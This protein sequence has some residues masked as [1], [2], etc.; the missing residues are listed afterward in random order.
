[1]DR[2]LE[3]I[4]GEKGAGNGNRWPMLI[5]LLALAIVTAL[6][7]RWMSAG[8]ELRPNVAERYGV[9]ARLSE[10][11]DVDRDWLGTANPAWAGALIPSEARE[12]CREIIV[13]LPLQPGD[14]LTITNQSGINLAS[15]ER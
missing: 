2:E 5:V 6:V 1:M 9:Q 3:E 7:A 11:Y 14:T 10:L 12:A 13:G 4:L 8:P 15:C